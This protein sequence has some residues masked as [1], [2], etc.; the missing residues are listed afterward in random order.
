MGFGMKVA[1]VLNL[2]HKPLFG[3]EKIIVPEGWRVKPRGATIIIF[4]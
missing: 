3:M 4:Q 1:Y 2:T